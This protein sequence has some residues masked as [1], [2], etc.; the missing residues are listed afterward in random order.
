VCLY[1][2]PIGNVTILLESR[3]GLR[4]VGRI[5]IDFVPAQIN[6]PEEKGV[7]TTV[8]VTDSWRRR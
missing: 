8:E 5:D 6:A 2:I 4:R 1:R 3:T 7:L